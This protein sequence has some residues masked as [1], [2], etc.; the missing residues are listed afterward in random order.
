MI[1]SDTKLIG[2]LTGYIIAK[3]LSKQYAVHA[4]ETVE[5][6]FSLEVIGEYTPIIAALI[7]TGNSNV[8]CPTCELLS[9]EKVNCKLRNISNNSVNATISIFV[10]YTKS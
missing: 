5:V 4:N 10:I 6:D 9:S 7:K 3:R 2:K 8:F 1:R